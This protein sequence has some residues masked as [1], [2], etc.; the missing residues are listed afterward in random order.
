MTINAKPVLI[1]AGIDTDSVSRAV[2]DTRRIVENADYP[3]EK[4]LDLIE[5]LTG[6]RKDYTDTTLA[7]HVAQCVVEAVVK[8]DLIEPETVIAEAEKRSAALVK[9]MPWINAKPVAANAVPTTQVAVAEGIDVKVEVKADGKIK[10]GGKQILAV[11]LYKKHVT[12]AE[13]PVTNQEFIA[14]LMKEL[15]M[16]KAGSTT[17]AYNC[18]KAAQK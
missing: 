16:T 5:Q 9:R 8:S 2:Q 6:I 10:K 4:A 3:R 13:K 12:E 14:I 7:L 17:Y 18:K 1:H 11:E 15:G